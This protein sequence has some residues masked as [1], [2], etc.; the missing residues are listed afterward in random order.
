MIGTAEQLPDDHPAL[1]GTGRTTR[2]LAGLPDGGVY[3]VA[4][5][6]STQHCKALLV[7]VLG[8]RSDAVRFV[9]L[10]QVRH[11]AL[12]GLSRT[13]PIDV[14]HHAWH[15]ARCDERQAVLMAADRYLPEQEA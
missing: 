13:T 8:R 5:Q 15:V 12:R 3:V 1:R 6:P 9:T 10:E 11:S 4:H 7:D 2:Q 14:D